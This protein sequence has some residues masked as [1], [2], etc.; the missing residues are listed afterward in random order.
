MQFKLFLETEELYKQF[1]SY[2]NQNNIDFPQLLQKLQSQNPDGQGGNAN[3][4][5]ITNTPF[6][7]RILKKNWTTP[8]T[9]PTLQPANNPNSDINIGQAIAHYGKNIQVLRLQQGIPAGLK[10]GAW[11]SKNDDE[12]NKEIANYKNQIKTAAEMPIDSYIELFNNI[13]KLNANNYVV[14][15]S[16]S[17]NLLIDKDKQKFNIVDMNYMGDKNTYKNSADEIA[18]MLIDKF[19]T[20]YFPTDKEVQNYA[21]QIHDKIEQAAELTKLTLKADSS[22]YQFQK[23]Y[24]AGNYEPPTPYV[25]TNNNEVW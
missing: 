14:D 11:N 15:P 8:D 4:Y 6:G 12:L 10:H 1:T 22:S 16:K 20:K 2:L 5:K 18:L 7:I 25:P 17:G 9:N 24:A 19:A 21:K 13:K 23:K 3:F